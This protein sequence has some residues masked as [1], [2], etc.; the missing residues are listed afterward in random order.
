MPAL[1]TVFSVL[2]RFETELWNAVD[3]RPWEELHTRLGLAQ[4]VTFPRVPG[5]EAAGLVARCPGGS[6]RPAGRWP[7]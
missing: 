3:A 4:G 1:Q 5:I 2:I 6:S 7:R